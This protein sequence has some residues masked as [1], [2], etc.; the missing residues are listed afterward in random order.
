L[1]CIE[2]GE[3]INVGRGGGSELNPIHVDDAVD[4]TV[5]A[6]TAPAL[7]SVINIAGPEVVTMADMLGLLGLALGRAPIIRERDQADP[8]WAA[9]IQRMC[10]HLGAPEIGLAEGIQREWG[11]V[12]R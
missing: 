2:R 9:D 10:E 12:R 8:S 4:A 6:M 7:P 11:R 3:P 1:A 5:R